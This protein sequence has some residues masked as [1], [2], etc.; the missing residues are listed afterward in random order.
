MEKTR[1]SAIITADGT[2]ELPK[3]AGISMNESYDA[4]SLSGHIVVPAKTDMELGMAR[5]LWES[6][7][8]NFLIG[9]SGNSRAGLQAELREGDADFSGGKITLPVEMMSLRALQVRQNGVRDSLLS[10]LAEMHDER[11]VQIGRLLL[12]KPNG[13]LDRAGI[14]DAIQ[15]N[16][17]L[18]NM[19]EQQLEEHISDEGV[20]ELPLENLHFAFCESNFRTEQMRGMIRYGKHGLS[21]LQEER[22]GKQSTL[23]G[24]EFFVGGIRI[25]IGP[26]VAVIDSETNEEGVIHLA[27]RVLDGVRTTGMGV[28]R[29]VELFNTLYSAVSTE[30]LAVNVRFYHASKDVQEFSREVINAQTLQAGVSLRDVLDI[31]NRPELIT[32]AIGSVNPTVADGDPAGYFVGAG[33][34]RIVSWVDNASESFQNANLRIMTPKFSAGD[35]DYCSRKDDIPHHLRP[36]ASRLG[37]IG[38]QQ[39]A[40]MYI[41]DAFPDTDTMEHMR[42]AGINVFVAHHMRPHE[43]AYSAEEPILNAERQ[44]SVVLPGDKERTK[45]YPLSDVFMTDQEFAS[46]QRIHAKGV[47]LLYVRQP[48]ADKFGEVETLPEEVMQWHERGFWVKPE[49]REAVEKVDTLIA[50]YGSHVKPIN[51]AM[52]PQIARFTLRMKQLFGDKAGMMHGRGHGVMYLADRAARCLP[53]Y[54][55]QKG[56]EEFSDITEPMVSVGIGIDLEQVG[57][58]INHHPDGQMNFKSQSRLIRQKHMNDRASFNVINLGGAG[59]LEEIALTLCSQK[60][61]KNLM[62]PMIFVDPFGISNE[63]GNFWN[64]LKDFIADLSTKKSITLDEKE[65]AFQLL[66]GHMQ[67]MMHV[68]DNYDEAA[69]IIEGFVEDPVGY[70]AAADVTKEEFEHSFVNAMD[71]RRSTKFPMPHWMN[72][73]R[74]SDMLDDERWPTVA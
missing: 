56:N 47:E 10:V 46:V 70:Y 44:V 58:D 32:N 6:G 2:L 35:P 61:Y 43:D 64:K 18:F 12:T 52:E 1:R 60:L 66:Q 45:M 68:V 36:L 19:R 34:S 42:D 26:Y 24:K 53:E 55:K 4:P 72:P 29:Q 15:S 14:M 8:R 20:L 40:K 59:T 48:A 7:D 16:Q 31:Q 41:S 3:G 57:Q 13:H 33:A 22:H 11:P 63:G 71:I 38:G 69:D 62:T 23:D 49:S 17:L 50:M 21:G 39:S 51:E 25:A 74:Y 30:N 67:N 37:M 5:D 65:V 73:E 27:A 54:A 9:K 28:V